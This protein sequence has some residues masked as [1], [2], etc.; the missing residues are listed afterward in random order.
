MADIGPG[1]EGNLECIGEDVDDKYDKKGSEVSILEEK[2]PDLEL[3][4]S[5]TTRDQFRV[6]GNGV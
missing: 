6:G 2:T 1:N 3:E 4:C 5:R